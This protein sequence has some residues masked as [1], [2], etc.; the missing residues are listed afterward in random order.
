[1]R[2]LVLCL[3]LF[4]LCSCDAHAHFSAGATDAEKNQRAAMCKDLC[5]KEHYSVKFIRHDGTIE[6]HK[7]GIVSL[8]GKTACECKF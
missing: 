7:I 2:R 8:S 5:N 3:S 4:I 1:M 6:H